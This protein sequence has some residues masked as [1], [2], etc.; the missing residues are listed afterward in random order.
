MSIDSP[1]PTQQSRRERPAKS[2][3]SREAIID[4]ASVILREEGVQ[5]V[6]MRRVARELDT[7]HASLYVYV[8][9]TED[10]HAGI[11]DA[12]LAAIDSHPSSSGQWA[13]R[14][15]RLLAQFAGVLFEHPEIARMA[16]TTRPSG[17]HYTALVEAVLA[18]LVEGGA[19]DRAAAWGVDLLLLYPVSIAAEHSS[20]ITTGSE[21]HRPDDPLAVDA[22]T[23]P[24]IARLGH[25]LLSGSGS[26][27]FDWALD[28]LLRGIV[29]DHA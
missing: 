26:D 17:P 12:R 29:D 13:T 25:E 9:D 8:R 16:V 2:P 23:H 5:K 7:G 15:K 11:L 4:A 14:L 20:N 19:S 24:Q 10:L 18:L 27:R 28:V 21:A 6:T 1:A 22:T 3:L